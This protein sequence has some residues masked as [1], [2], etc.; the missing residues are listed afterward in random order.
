M[1]VFFSFVYA[2]A[3]GVLQ[4]TS[5]IV[6]NSLYLFYYYFISSFLFL[7]RLLRA[8][9][10]CFWRYSHFSELCIH[11]QRILIARIPK[12]ELY[13]RKKKRRKN[14]ISFSAIVPSSSTNTHGTVLNCWEGNGEEEEI[15]SLFVGVIYIFFFFRQYASPPLW[16]GG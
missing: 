10:K 11:T 6:Y 5:I 7:P 14:V 16:R 13:Q 4:L 9:A 8:T 1:C 2:S 3:D 12:S 15:P